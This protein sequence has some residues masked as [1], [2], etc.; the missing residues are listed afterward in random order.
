MSFAEFSEQAN[1]R[2]VS[3]R[4][5]MAHSA[6]RFIGF[7]SANHD[8]RRIVGRRLSAKQPLIAARWTSAENTYRVEL[9]HDLSDGHE[10]RHRAEGLAPEVRVGARD[11]HAAPSVRERGH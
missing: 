4:N 6:P 7:R 10:L 2:G 3:G 11:D 8:L 5:A 9:I 1:L